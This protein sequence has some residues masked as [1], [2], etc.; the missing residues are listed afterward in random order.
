[1]TLKSAMLKMTVLALTIGSGEAV[2]AKSPA[3]SDKVLNIAFEA[4]DD[5][6]DMVK[7]YNF[8]SGSIAEA[9]FEPLLRYDYL[10]RPATL[11]PNTR[12]EEHTSELQS[13]ENL[14]CRLLLEKK[15]NL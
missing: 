6:F 12:S 8:Y 9:I 2:L 1:M 11:T 15:T 10:A 13:R 3:Q 4:P 7:T 14:V 5:G